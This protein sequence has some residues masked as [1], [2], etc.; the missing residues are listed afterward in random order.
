MFCRN[1][2]VAVDA[3]ANA[4]PNC[5]AL[6]APPVAPVAPVVTTI[7]PEEN[8][9]L[10]AGAYFGLKILF[11]VPII[12]FIFLIIFSCKKDNIN[13][14][15]FALSYWFALLVAVIVILIFVLLGVVADVSLNNLF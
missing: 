2:G 6:Q 7:L 9:P 14:R 12:G 10:S 8:R 15:N 4:C 13:R 1:C 3:A 11:A 5:G